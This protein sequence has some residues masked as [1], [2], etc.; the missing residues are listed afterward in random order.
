MV[1]SRLFHAARWHLKV[2]HVSWWS[3]TSSTAGHLGE[4]TRIWWWTFWHM[5]NP[6]W[7]P[8]KAR[9]ELLSMADRVRR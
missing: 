3:H 1:N 8:N 4:I 5:V 2:R 9:E 6:G 7:Y